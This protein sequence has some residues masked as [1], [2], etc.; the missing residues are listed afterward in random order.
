MILGIVL[1][2]TSQSDV[3]DFKRGWDFVCHTADAMHLMV[4][5]FLRSLAAD[6]LT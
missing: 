4:V 5:N 1:S 6:L 2:P 3:I